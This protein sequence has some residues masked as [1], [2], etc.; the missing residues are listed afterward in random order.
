VL[1]VATLPLSA[2]VAGVVVF[3]VG[4]AGRALARRRGV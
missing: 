1:L 4:L 3:A 2:V